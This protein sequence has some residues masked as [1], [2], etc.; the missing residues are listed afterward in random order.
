M[1]KI[2]KRSLGTL[3]FL[4]L[5]LSISMGGCAHYRLTAPESPPLDAFGEPPYGTGQICVLRPHSLGALV[6]IAVRD[7]GSL[8]GATRGP[9]Y[10]CYLVQPGLHDVTSDSGNVARLSVPVAPGARIYLQQVINI[11]PDELIPLDEE[12]AAALLPRCEYSQL[13][14]PAPQDLL[15]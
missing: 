3:Q 2:T 10:F 11:G 8:V 12:R 15:R 7:N 9:S 6:T 14:E 13:I 4:L 1:R 5:S